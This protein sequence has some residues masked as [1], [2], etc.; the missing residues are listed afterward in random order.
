MSF[1]LGEWVT[2]DA[3]SS[4]VA[5]FPDSFQINSQLSAFYDGESPNHWDEDTDETKASGTCSL[6]AAMYGEDIQD[7]NDIWEYNSE[8]VANM[9]AEDGQTINNSEEGSCNSVAELAAE[10]SETVKD[11][12]ECNSHSDADV[13]ANEIVETGSESTADVQNVGDD[14]GEDSISL[15]S[16][17]REDAPLV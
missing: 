11:N 16:H 7:K 5:Q 6:V 15:E 13:F 12:G 1:D 2:N 14:E 4:I 10:D 17:T 3:R 8:S 9:F